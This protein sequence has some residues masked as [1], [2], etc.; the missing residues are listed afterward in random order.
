MKYLLLILLFAACASTAPVVN[1]TPVVTPPVVA[2]IPDP[3]TVHIHDT[4][5]KT[6]LSPVEYPVGR[7]T[8]IAGD[9]VK[10]DHTGQGLYS[11]NLLQVWDAKLKT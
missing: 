8:A 11:G 6:L 4:V 3:D 5:F 1:P 9:T 10:W 7:V 2:P